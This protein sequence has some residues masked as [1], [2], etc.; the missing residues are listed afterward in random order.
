MINY[1]LFALQFIC[2]FTFFLAACMQ[3]KVLPSFSMAAFELF[4]KIKTTTTTTKT[5]T[6]RAKEKTEHLQLEK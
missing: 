2:S 5:M 6:K 3:E 1:R 4:I